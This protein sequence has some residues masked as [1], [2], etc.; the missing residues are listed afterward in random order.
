MATCFVIQP[1]DAG[2]F[3]K[4]YEQVFVPAITAARLDPYRVDKDFRA[5]VPI[6]AIEAGIT[7]AS[8]CLADI[9]TDN[10]NVWYEL[11]YSFAVGVPVVMVCAE[12]R[13]GKKYPFDIQHRKV[14]PYLSD[15]PNDFVELRDSITQRL[16]AATESR[17]NIRRMA[18]SDI[19]A[20][21]AGLGQHEMTVLSTVAAIAG[22]PDGYA[23][24][25][26]VQQGGERAGLTKLGIT[27]GMRG[28]ISKSFVRKVD[29]QRF[30]DD[31]EA[32]LEVTDAGWAWIET[33]EGKFILRKNVQDIPDEDIP[34]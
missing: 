32:A 11:G 19:V 7:A 20:P 23:N 31:P 14:L 15:A 8:V 10:P 25:Y 18:E 34:F 24:I 9:T 17:A 6:Q 30:N 4:R 26:S 12:V 21:I 5:D 22:I 1:F 27:L 3:D 33:N 2:R 28:L 13:E 16:L 29:I